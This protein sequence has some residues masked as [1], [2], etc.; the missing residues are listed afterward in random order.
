MVH[1]VTAFLSPQPHGPSSIRPPT[2]FAS[3]HRERKGM[4]HFQSGHSVIRLKISY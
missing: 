1:L 4:A 3:S 2:Y